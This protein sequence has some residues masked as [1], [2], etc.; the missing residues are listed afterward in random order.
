[1]QRSVAWF[2]AVALLMSSVGGC[3]DDEPAAD[4]GSDHDDDHGKA[5]RG[6][7]GGA[8]GKGGSSGASGKGG[9]GGSGGT[10]GAGGG[11]ATQAVTIRFKAKIGS[12]DLE[13]GKSYP[14]LGKTM[15]TATPQDFRFF[16]EELSLIAKSGD[17]VKVQFDE[18]S[19][20]QTKDV[21][22]IDFTNNQGSCT[23]G[24]ATVN[25]T[26]TG[27]VPPGEY[28]GVEFVNGVP[29][30]L[31]HQNITLAKPPLQDI[32]TYWGWASG[33]RFVMTGLL[34]PTATTN[35]ADDAGADST[36]GS[37]FVHIGSTACSGGAATGFTC[38]HPN[39]N[40]VKLENFDVDDDVIIADLGKVFAD[41][42]LTSG[43]ECHGT[44]D[45]CKSAYEAFGVNMDSGEALDT[46]Q[47]FRVE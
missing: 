9:A 3:G 13:C 17:K 29:E 26:I 35:T 15:Q 21:A 32:S 14:N 22:L 38:S 44:G 43:V 20:F 10:G 16:V 37:N 24:G 19:P 46:Q 28:S 12:E 41:V 33:Y 4:G 23:A 11:G 6:G 1:M 36:S 30:T 18:R 5:G 25:T 31:N 8:G 7:K 27:K 47:V 34:V 39:R 42:D 2:A 45:D 40:R